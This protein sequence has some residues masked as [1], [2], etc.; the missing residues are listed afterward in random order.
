MKKRRMLSG[1]LA[2]V[3]SLMVLASPALAAEGVETA[4]ILPLYDKIGPQ[5][6][7]KMTFRRYIYVDLG[8]RHEY[9]GLFSLYDRG[10]TWYFVDNGTAGRGTGRPGAGTAGGA[11]AA[12]GIGAGDP[13]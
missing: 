5:W 7:E 3:M 11:C 6:R 4:V 10:V 13:Q 1:A 9:C 2:L 8:W 12:G